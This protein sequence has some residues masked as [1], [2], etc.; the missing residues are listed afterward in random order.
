MV[1]VAS[2]CGYT[3]RYDGLEKLARGAGLERLRGARL[4]QRLRRPG[5]GHGRGD[6]AV[7]QAD[8]RRHLPDVRKERHEGGPRPVADLRLSRPDRQPSAWNFSKYLVGKDG[9]VIAFY[10]SKVKPDAP[11]LRDATASDRELTSDVSPCGLGLQFSFQ[12]ACGRGQLHWPL[13]MP[14]DPYG[15][16][17]STSLPS[18]SGPSPTAAATPS[19]NRSASRRR[20]TTHGAAGQRWVPGGARRQ[21]RR[22]RSR[23]HRRHPVRTRRHRPQ[24][25][26]G[27]PDPRAGRARWRRQPVCD[28]VSRRR[29]TE[30][31][32]MV[33]PAR[34]ADDARWRPGH[35]AGR[36]I[37]VLWGG[38]RRHRD[39]RISR[40]PDEAVKS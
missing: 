13:P 11:E 21:L 27:L 23:S 5:T 28:H 33:R 2:K 39:R 25:Q 8:L 36:E 4:E 29:S 6:S 24:L 31:P 37:F 10:P 19:A 22:Q 12:R 30:R 35:G 7:L 40:R 14:T 34:A 16:A 1:N 26:E 15:P 38:R 3:P 9:K 32:S 18:D 17:P 20:Q